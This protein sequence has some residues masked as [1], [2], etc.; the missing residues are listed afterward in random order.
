[1]KKSLSLLIITIIALTSSINASGQ[2]TDRNTFNLKGPVK[3]VYYNGSDSEPLKF[4]KNGKLIVKKDQKDF[5]ERDKKGRITN[6]WK[7]YKIYEYI[8]FDKYKVLC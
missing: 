3:A 7:T 2:W 4:D 5:I 6:I 1:M 8:G